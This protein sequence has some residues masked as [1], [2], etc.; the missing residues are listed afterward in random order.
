MS[1]H[2]RIIRI[3]WKIWLIQSYTH[4]FWL[5]DDVIMHLSKHRIALCQLS[6][7]INVC[8]NVWTYTNAIVSTWKPPSRLDTSR[9]VC[10]FY[11]YILNAILELVCERSVW[12]MGNVVQGVQSLTLKWEMSVSKMQHYLI[13][14][15]FPYRSFVAEIYVIVLAIICSAWSRLKTPILLWYETV[16]GTK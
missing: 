16:G 15:L 1:Q 4:H 14:H 9:N 8:I 12:M 5:D 13:S 10:F 2:G 11:L 3:I 7:H 6:E